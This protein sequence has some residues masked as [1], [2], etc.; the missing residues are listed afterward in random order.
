MSCSNCVYA[1]SP[2][3]KRGRLRWFHKHLVHIGHLQAVEIPID[4]RLRIGDD[5]TIKGR[6]ASPPHERSRLY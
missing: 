2:T 4:S 3:S 6:G 5:R 1:R